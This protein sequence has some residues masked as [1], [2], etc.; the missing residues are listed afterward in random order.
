MLLER[1]ADVRK[2][3]LTERMTALGTAVR[4]D[5]QDIVKM[6]LDIGH[7]DVN[8]PCEDDNTPLMIA[9]T[10]GDQGMADLLLEHHA[11]VFGLYNND[12]ESVEDV[13][14]KHG[15]VELANYLQAAGLKQLGTGLQHE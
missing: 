1:N 5:Y 6:L 2:R 14:L 13:A 15:H 10:K 3:T 11:E 7:A 9:A 4:E 8:Q 12:E